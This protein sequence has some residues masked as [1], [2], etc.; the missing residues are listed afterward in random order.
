M[1]SFYKTVAKREKAEHTVNKSIFI[2]N[3]APV[4]TEKEAK[5]F[6]DSIK[7]Q[8]HDARHNCYAYIV[9]ENGGKKKCSDDG[10][11]SGTAG[12]P[13]LEVLEK[14]EITDA[15]I[16]VTRYFGGILLGAGGLVR[17]YS[18]AAGNVV[19]ICELINMRLCDIISF[20]ANYKDAETLKNIIEKSGIFIAEITYGEKVIIKINIPENES[21]E[22]MIK[23]KFNGEITAKKVGQMYARVNNAD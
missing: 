18:T 7:K 9:N 20:E 5:A 15:A 19:K 16:V 8:Y 14:N 2:A 10:E 17:A 13:I 6:I 22:L 11:P 4:A 1:I 3:I 21:E 23:L 12:R